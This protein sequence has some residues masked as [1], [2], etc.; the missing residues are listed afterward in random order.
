[1][2]DSRKERILR[3]IV[4]EY[5][6]TCEPVGS[7]CLHSKYGIE[8][9]TATIRN[10][11][12]EMEEM[13]YLVQPHTSAG[14]I[15]SDKAYRMYVND[16]MGSRVPAEKVLSEED[17]E[18]IKSAL[19]EKVEEAGD[20]LK[21]VADIVSSVTDYTS[22]AITP[23]RRKSVV[24]ALQV[25]P[26]Q[27]GMCL[28]MVVTE[29]GATNS[30]VVS[31]PQDVSR[32]YIISFS[33]FLN[34]RLVGYTLESITY[35]LC[36]SLA[37]DFELDTDVLMPVVNGIRKCIRQMDDPHIVYDGTNKIFKH[38]EFNDIS[39]AQQFMELMESNRLLTAGT[40]EED[41][42]EGDDKYLIRIG[43]ENSS[44]DLRGLSMLASHCVVGD[45]LL[46]DIGIIGPTRMDYA[47][48]IACLNYIKK[49][50]DEE[51]KGELQ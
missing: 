17:I 15:P 22:F 1:M 43:S 46:G 37:M 39:R 30:T 12:A 38:P 18:C 29:S 45:D 8:F 5:I 19:H 4:E 10:D 11:M 25:I 27:P 28:V 31:V 3:A 7:K 21:K 23:S 50:I 9:S 35:D 14:R 26:A 6:E 44:D 20:M 13:G 2:L 41:Y 36:E 42:A 33:E 40:M 51:L 49:F 48:V 32:E 24:S 47:K 34:R 16:I